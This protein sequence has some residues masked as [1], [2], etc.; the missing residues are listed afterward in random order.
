MDSRPP[1]YRSKNIGFRCIKIIEGDSI[2]S[3]VFEPQ[4]KPWNPDMRKETPCSDEVFKT[5]KSFYSYSKTELDA[6]VESSDETREDYVLEKVTFNAAYGGER[7]IA[8]LHLPKKKY[9]KPLQIVIFFPPAGLPSSINDYPPEPARTIA[10][11]GRVFVFPVY[12][13][14]FERERPPDWEATKENHRDHVI[15]TS[16]DLG[17]TI[18]YLETR[19]D[20]DAD[21]IAYFGISWGAWMG[22]ILNAVEDR[23]KALILTAGGLSEGRYLPEVRPLNFAKHVTAPTLILNGK[24]DRFFTVDRNV[25]VLLDLLGTAKEDKKLK[26]LEAS[27]DVWTNNRY[28]REVLDWLDRYLGQVE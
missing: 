9:K 5:F 26:L 7:M 2:P 20:L 22:I 19:E 18:D 27:H 24:Y 3:F 6:V 25:K 1:F 14:V 16:K 10:K 23:T 8:Y 28:R 11:S 21:K 15:M 13:D 4:K 17:R 12:H